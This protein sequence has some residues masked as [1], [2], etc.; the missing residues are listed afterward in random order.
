MERLALLFLSRCRSSKFDEAKCNDQ[1]SFLSRKVIEE[2]KIYSY[3]PKGR[4]LAL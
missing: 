1:F 4:F 2:S 3:C